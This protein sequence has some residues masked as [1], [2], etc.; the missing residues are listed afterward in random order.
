MYPQCLLCD[1]CILWIKI[2]P[3]KVSLLELF[4]TKED[5]L[6]RISQIL[7]VWITATIHFACFWHSSQLKSLTIAFPPEQNTCPLVKIQSHVTIWASTQCPNFLNFRYV[8][9]SPCTHWSIDFAKPFNK[10]PFMAAAATIFH[11]ADRLYCSL[12]SAFITKCL[13][14]LLPSP[15]LTCNCE[16]NDDEFATGNWWYCFLPNSRVMFLIKVKQIG[17][18]PIKLKEAAEAKE[19][20]Y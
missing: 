16:S 11:P 13:L 10:I 3:L 4:Q 12:F 19:V 15:P 9:S 18:W 1:K 5:S 2:F 8:G 6:V 20:W 17:P 14:F 7:S